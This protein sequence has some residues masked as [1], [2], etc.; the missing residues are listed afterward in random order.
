MWEHQSFLLLLIDLLRLGQLFVQFVDELIFLSI[1][2]GQVLYVQI[3]I[4]KLFL[5]VSYLFLLIVHYGKFWVY[6]LRRGI[7]NLRS[8]RCIIKCAQIFFKV[9]VWRR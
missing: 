3:G 7:W 9:L 6:I 2:A 4:F 1:Q 8:L 5:E